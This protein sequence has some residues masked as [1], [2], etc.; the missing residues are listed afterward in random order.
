MGTRIFSE[1]IVVLH[2]S[3]LVHASVIL[4]SADG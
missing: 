1:I 3:K 4:T 2:Y